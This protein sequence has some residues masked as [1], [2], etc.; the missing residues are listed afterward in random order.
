MYACRVFVFSSRDV[1]LALPCSRLCAGMDLYVKAMRAQG[2]IP[3]ANGQSVS[4]NFVYIKCVSL[5]HAHSH[6]Q[7]LH[8]GRRRWHARR[9]D[10]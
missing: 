6:H 3:L 1:C 9:S 5:A 10:Q 2:P 8:T 4:F 7:R